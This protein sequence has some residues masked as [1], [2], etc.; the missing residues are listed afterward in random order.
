MRETRFQHL[1]ALAICVCIGGC[2]ARTSMHSR[3]APNRDNRVYKKILLMTTYAD[4]ELDQAFEKKVKGCLKSHKVECVHER[5]LI[6]PSVG[7]DFER[8]GMA[9]DSA[10]IDAVLFVSPGSSGVSEH[11][12]PKSSTTSTTGNVSSNGSFKAKS[13]THEYGGYS[14]GKPWART[15]IELYDYSAGSVIWVARVPHP[16]GWV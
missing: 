2:A 6:F 11:Y 15:S 13:K 14:V 3:I 4:I 7:D 10:G 9:I 16:L 8:L 1:I 5:D 12:I